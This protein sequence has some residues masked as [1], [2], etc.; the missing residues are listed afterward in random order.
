MQ[1]EAILTVVAPASSYDLTTLDVIKD[2][3]SI[4]DN[5]KNT[6]LQ[7]YLSWASAA[8]ANECNRVFPMETLKEEV[9][10]SHERHLSSGLAV[11]QLCRWPLGAVATVTE[12]GTALASATDYRAN[13]ATGQMIRLST[14]G[15]L[16]H[17][18]FRTLVVEYTA[19]FDPIPGDLADAVTR[20][21]RNRY[22]A[23]GRDT[24]LISETI[25]GVRE[26]RWWMATGNE[27]GN[28]PPDIADL[29]D[30]YRV[31]VIA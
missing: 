1:L 17:W 16:R 5:S 24:Y 9:W 15:N 7:R 11:A 25:P 31:P 4:T 18:L 13:A 30:N 14:S 26:A 2:E 29:I 21:V 23:K 8:I 12:D 20:M 22:R 19:G 10:A 28:M 3:L 6:V 27:A